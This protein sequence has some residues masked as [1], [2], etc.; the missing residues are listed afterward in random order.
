MANIAALGIVAILAVVRCF[1][2]IPNLCIRW[3][4]AS[5]NL[6]RS[7]GRLGIWFSLGAL[8][9]IIIENLD[10]TVAARIISLESVTTLSLTGRVYLLSAGLLAQITNTARPALGQLVGQKDLPSL[11]AAYRRLFALSTGG[12]LVLGLSLWAGN[13]SFVSWWVGKQH[14]GGW[15][16]DLALA[17]NLIAHS[18]VLPNRA[19][20]SANLIVRPQTTSRIVE[21][22][23]NLGLSVLLA[24]RFGLLGIMIST[25]IAG[26]L[27]SCWYL[28]WLTARIFRRSYLRFMLDDVGGLVVV[29]ALLAPVAWWARL[30]GLHLQGLLGCAAAGI[31]TALAGV[32][33]LY[34]VAFD[35]A[36]RSRLHSA[37]AAAR[38]S[39]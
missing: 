30:L 19:V 1:R 9:G 16:L 5:W 7:M 12:A 21:G 17:L 28:P 35:R 11:M 10:R 29:G 38:A 3:K 25:S 4:Y 39:L 32:A 37:L 18:W 20:L 27:T 13:G 36:T 23:L 14:Y 34:V 15:A 8:A 31:I 22:A 6:L 33:L 26:G 24:R 2:T